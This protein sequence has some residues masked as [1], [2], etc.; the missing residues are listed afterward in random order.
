MASIVRR[1][2]GGRIY[3]YL[4]HATAT[5]R[6]EIYLGKEVPANIDE[7]KEQLMLDMSRGRWAGAL[8]GILKR[9][10][11]ERRRM[12]AKVRRELLEQFIVSFTYATQRVEGSTMTFRETADLLLHGSVPMSRPEHERREALA[13]RDI[14][15]DMVERRPAQVTLN[16][17]LRWHG[18]I[19]D[20]TDHAN[21]GHLRKYA[22]GIR[23]SKSEFPLWED[24]PGE[25]DRFFRWYRKNRRH[26]DAA[27]LA[28]MAHCKFVSI[29]PFGDGNGRMSR[30]LMNRILHEGGY[31]MFAVTM[32]DRRSYMRALERSQL[33]RNCA[34][35]VAWF[36]KRYVAA[37]RR[38]GGGRKAAPRRAPRP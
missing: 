12:P 32:K 16:L 11:E 6:R 26:L 35:F 33:G 22:V 18:R 20:H 8:A 9:H 17:L 30:L 19:F 24:V 3:Y 25:L 37:N 28:A 21:A 23:G 31:P 38:A 14:L 36:M 29:H 5:A 1:N 10:V 15:L 13:Q 4:K 2:R 34:P 27:E 7:I